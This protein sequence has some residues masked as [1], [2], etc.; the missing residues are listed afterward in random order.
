[1]K[2]PFVCEFGFEE[3]PASH[4]QSMLAQLSTE[5]IEAV[6]AKH[7]IS[8]TRPRIFITPRRIALLADH[9]EPVQKILEVKGPLYDAAFENG[10]PNTIAVKFSQSHGTTPDKLAIREHDGKKFLFV[11][12]NLAAQF[13]PDLQ[14]CLTDLIKG[15]ILER[16]MRWDD[17]GIKFSRPIRWILCLQGRHIIPI[18][19]GNLRAGNI[20]FGPR[21]NG[22]RSFW[23]SH[24]GTY[25][26]GLAKN[27]IIVDHRK[28]R[29][30]I[31]QILQTLEKA[32]NLSCPFQCDEL[33]NEVTFLV[34]YP[35]PMICHFNKQFLSLPDKVISTVLHKHQRYFPLFDETTKSISHMFLVIANYDKDSPLIAQG[36]EIVVNA[37]L[38][39]A[40][41]FYEQ[42]L[43]TTLQDLSKKTDSI[44]FQEN[45]GS[46]HDKAKR[47]EAI[48]KNIAKS[49]GQPTEFLAQAASLSKADLASSL[50]I[51][52]PSLEGTMG[53]IY[54]KND[55]LDTSVARAIEEHYLPR[56]AQDSLP[57]S[58]LGI[59]LALAD[60]IDTLYSLF[61]INAV[62]KG[63]SDPYGLR[64][65]AIGIIRIL[66]EKEIPLKV[67]ELVDFASTTASKKADHKALIDFILQR[68]E[69]N[70]HDS[71]YSHMPRHTN[72]LRAVVF[73]SDL[74]ILHKKQTLVSLSQK[75]NISLLEKVEA[76]AKRIYNIAVKNI[77]AA[78]ASLKATSLNKSEQSFFNAI[79]KLQRKDILTIEDL[80][81]LV[82]P[83]NAFFEGNMVMSDVEGE[84]K[85]RLAL[86]KL[87]HEQIE[88]VINVKYILG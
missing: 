55:D 1:M 69:Q 26:D 86:L 79:T 78:P 37:R 36:N 14:A 17:S 43:M 7:N 70:I 61:S 58:Q 52:F 85:R 83:G 46:M 81:T 44:T 2:E 8:F 10:K 60:R 51:E 68:V 71:G 45:L 38:R 47:I 73:N 39:D 62:P 87:A 88:R 75:N 49:L 34:E 41:F 80:S 3:L 82:A 31:E 53:K 77:D 33:I 30:L 72:V 16:P 50:V 20:T 56:S 25:E 28:R 59:T 15:I 48:S 74:S 40:I 42:D 19:F 32:Q 29:M 22:S 21:F 12:K 18:E 67:S 57:E 65:A 54:A 23:I 6:A 66:W 11:S 24:A 13:V 9:V 64:R 76:I 63:N 5:T 84:R 27:R 4:C 35:H